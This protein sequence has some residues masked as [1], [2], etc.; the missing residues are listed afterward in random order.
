[1]RFLI[2]GL[3]VFVLLAAGFAP[4][5]ADHRKRAR[6]KPT[7]CADHIVKDLTI[8][9]PFRNHSCAAVALPGDADGDGVAD[10]AD[11]CPD[12]PK[13]ATVDAKGCP[14]DSD[15]DGAYDG[16]DE[17]PDTPKG[18]KVNAKGCPG[19]D[20]GDGVYDGIDR[21]E[22]T[23]R[24]VEVDEYG[25]PVDVTETE[26]EFLDTGMIRTSN[27]TFESAKADLKPESH[28]VLDE[29][30]TILV[31][32]PELE[33]E[34]GGHTD[35]QGAESLNQKLSEDRAKSVRDYLVNRFPKIDKGNL[36]TKGYG[37]GSPIADNAT[38]EGRA[39]NRRVE[40]KVLNKETLKKEI[41]R[42]KRW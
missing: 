3:A 27:V 17:C 11:A 4:A 1:M 30:G 16:I 7:V 20:D 26:T 33:I 39:Q 9:W 31:Q 18:A 22:N 32:W 25:C 29:I 8:P 13:G 28:K 37:E 24:G 12:T 2:A 21:C 40:F 19:D 10:D 5:K 23:P 6:K 42:K 35:A 36:S 41:E 38:A 34:I 14:T 15:G